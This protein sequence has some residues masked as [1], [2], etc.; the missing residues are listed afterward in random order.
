MTFDGVMEK[1]KEI[2][3]LLYERPWERWELLTIAAGLFVFLLLLVARRR[4]KARGKTVY[5]GHVPERTT[6]IGTKLAGPNQSGK[7]VN[8]SRKGSA[9]HARKA[10]ENRRKWSTAAEQPGGSDEAVRQLRCEIIKR[11]QIE[12]QLKHEVAELKVAGEEVRQES[13]QSKQ[14]EE[15]LKEQAAEATAGKEQLQREL[16][17]SRQTEENLKRKVGELAVA[18]EQLQQEVTESRQAEERLKLKVGEL[19]VADEQLLQEADERQKADPSRGDT[20]Y[21]DYHRVAD[22]AEQKLC[23]KCDE[24]KARSEFH[25]DASCKDGLATWCKACKTKAARESHQGRTAAKD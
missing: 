14:F 16:A 25:K 11:D 17:E 20:R 19:T 24:W 6:I 23:R 13:A 9:A 3:F 12:A 5:A 10:Q 1:V 4:R 2:L 8:K 21:D 18:N 15:R 7:S 22:G